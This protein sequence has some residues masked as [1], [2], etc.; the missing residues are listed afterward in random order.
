MA[1]EKKNQTCK[2]AT[3]YKH[4]V[5]KNQFAEWNWSRNE[6]DDLFTIELKEKVMTYFHMSKKVAYW[7]Y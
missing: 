2:E 3:K 6:T 4:S 7:T 5:E 1:S